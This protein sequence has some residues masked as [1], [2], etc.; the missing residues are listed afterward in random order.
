M[1]AA[2]MMTYSFQ[3]PGGCRL[4]FVRFTDRAGHFF[5]PSAVQTTFSPRSA[6]M[7]RVI[8]SS[9]RMPV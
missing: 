7:P 1:I 4:D 3:S 5:C 9:Y 2:A 8:L 6:M